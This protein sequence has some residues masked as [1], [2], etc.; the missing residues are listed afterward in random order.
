[1]PKLHILQGPDKGH[2]FD[3]DR[4]TVLVGRGSPDLPLA[5]NTISR[6][7]AEFICEDDHWFLRDLNSANGTYVNGV[8]VAQKLELKQGDQVRCGTTLMVFGG[9]KS[10][11]VMGTGSSLKIDEDGNLVESSIMATVRDRRAPR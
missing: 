1:M 10:A 3:I 8:K 9:E 11:G 6:K 5:D 4:S 7:H 2:S